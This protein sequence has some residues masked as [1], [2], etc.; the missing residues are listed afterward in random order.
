MTVGTRLTGARVVLPDAV[1]ERGVVTVADGLITGVAA[2]DGLPREP[3][4]RRREESGPPGADPGRDDGATTVD[5]A[6]RW[7][8]P[9]FVDMHVHGGGG[10]SYPS[11]DPEQALRAAAFHRAHGTTTTVA[12]LVTA[13]PSDLLDRVAALADLVTDG[14]LAGLHLEGP[15]LSRVRCGAHD[16]ALLRPP[17]AAETDALLRAG[18]GTVRMMTLAPELPGAVDLV[19][20]LADAGAVAAIGHTDA[21]HHQTRAALDA[22]ATVATHLFNGMRGL[23]HREP[24]PIAA[25]LR[26]G[27]VVVELINDTVHVHPD[28]V[29]LTFQAAGAARVALITDAMGAAG[30]PDGTYA[31]GPVATRVDGGI[32]RLAGTDT[33]A[34]STLT[35]DRALRNAVHGAGL[36]ITDVVRALTATPA[37]ALGLADRVGAIAPGKRADLVVLDADLHVAAVM[38][39]G[40]W[41][42][43]PG[44]PDAPRSP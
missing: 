38:R 36:P 7:L 37:T 5:L 18:R 3:R 34:G 10:A 35:L 11:G 25:L 28:V 6:G 15:Y 41:V 13:T 2:G 31:L 19:R 44:A 20:R 40:R 33:I 32:A 42:E 22:G 8:V 29:S 24:G 12:S 39:G 1:L 17:H 4:E 23:H 30:M 21:A 27:G 43:R 26:D 14:V 16:P 9:G